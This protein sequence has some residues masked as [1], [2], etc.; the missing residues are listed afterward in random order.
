MKNISQWLLF[1]SRIGGSDAV[2]HC[3]CKEGITTLF[4]FILTDFNKK[5]LKR[6]PSVCK[7]TIAAIAEDHIPN[8]INQQNTVPPGA[9]NISFISVQR[10]IVAMHAAAEYYSYSY[11][12]Q[13]HVLC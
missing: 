13:Q 1:H 2:A 6:L 10:L 8:G 3:I 4:D 11:R 5:S 7:E 9:N 12:S